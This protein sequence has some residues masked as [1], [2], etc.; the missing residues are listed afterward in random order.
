M[1]HRVFTL[2]LNITAMNSTSIKIFILVSPIYPATYL[3]LL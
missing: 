3:L 1:M 2:T